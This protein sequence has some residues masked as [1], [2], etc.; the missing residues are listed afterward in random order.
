[1]VCH[2]QG[3]EDPG[4]LWQ[5]EHPLSETVGGPETLG[6]EDH[7]VPAGDG[8]PTR[9]GCPS[10]L[11]P[12]MARIMAVAY[13]ELDGALRESQH[14]QS[15]GDEALYATT[16]CQGAPPPAVEVQPSMSAEATQEAPPTTTTVQPSD[17]A[18]AAQEAPPSTTTMQPSD[19]AEAAQ[20]APPTST[21]V[22]PSDSAEA[23]QETPPTTVQ[24]SDRA[25]AAQE[26]PPNTNTVQ[27]SPPVDTM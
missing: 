12:L 24:P 9:K 20:E 19:S 2:R 5:A 18:E 21:T 3:G 15:R 11:T 26:A 25:E 14:P 27:P 8:L 4:V 23:A 1:M 13:P 10:D 7:G 22:Q 16:S 17:S 6:T